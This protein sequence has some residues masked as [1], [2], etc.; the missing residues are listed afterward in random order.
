[1]SVIYHG[2]LIKLS[3]LNILLD[4]VQCYCSDTLGNG[5]TYFFA[6]AVGREED[7]FHYTPNLCKQVTLQI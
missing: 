3:I 7:I 6:G 4:Y 5:Q 1:M 2:P